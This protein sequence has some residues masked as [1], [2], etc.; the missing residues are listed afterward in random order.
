MQIVTY[1]QKREFGLVFKNDVSLD[2]IR[3]NSFLKLSL[4]F[5]L[6]FRYNYLFLMNKTTVEKL[7]SATVKLLTSSQ[8]ITSVSTAVKELLENSIDAGGKTIQVRLE[9]YGLDLIE[10]KDNGLGVSYDNVQKMFLPGYTSKIKQFE[11][12]G[13]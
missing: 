4:Y 7:P 5:F 13:T 1:H 9:N 8:V 3:I 10:V 6:F 12:L 2:K 11:D